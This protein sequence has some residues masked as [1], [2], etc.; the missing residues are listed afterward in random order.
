MVKNVRFL[1]GSL[2]VAA[3]AGVLLFAP[4]AQAAARLRVVT[5][6]YIDA[7]D[8]VNYSNQRVEANG[9]CNATSPGI[10][11]CYGGWYL[12]SPGVYATKNCHSSGETM[13]TKVIHNVPGSISPASPPA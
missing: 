1:V 10:V 9:T 6:C 4:K 13:D 2:L 8:G 3:C 11:E 12:E 5:S 7:G